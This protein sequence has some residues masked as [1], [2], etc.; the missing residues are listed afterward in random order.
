MNDNLF[1][2]LAA[3]FPADRDLPFLETADGRA[4]SWRELE[5]GT[6]RI[7]NLLRSLDAPAG[8]RVLVQV[9]KSPTAIL[10]YLGALRAGLVFVPINTAYREAETEYFLRDAE[11]AVVVCRPA[12][13]EW[14]SALAAKTG[15]ARVFTLDDSGDGGTLLDAAVAQPDIFET[16]AR[17][18]DDLAVIIYTSGT[19]GRSK[20]AML[21]H[22]NLFSNASTLHAF[23]GWR[24][25][26]VLLHVLPIFHVHGLF[27]A[28]HGALL[29]GARMIWLPKFDPAEVLR[30]LP[31]CTVFMA[32][33]TIYTRLL[34]LP[35][36]N[37]ALCKG[38]RLFVSGSAPLLLETFQ[39]FQTRTGHTILERYG[40]S[41]TVMI[42]S[43][44]YDPAL[45]PRLG[46]TVGLPLP[47]IEVRVVESDGT[48]A[49]PP[50]A[51]GHL[52][53][54][55]PNVCLGYWR[56]PDKTA[57]DFTADRWF[58]TGDM[59]RFGGGVADR[60]VPDTY[61]TIVGRSKELIITGGFNVYPK[62]IEGFLNE[63]PGVAES[64]VFGV[65]H[66]DF[67][68]AVT[69]AV[70]PRAG[71]TLDSE[72]IIRTLKS[73][74]ASFK[75]PKGVHVVAEI[76]RNAMGKVQRNVLRD[77]FG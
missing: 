60:N 58:K 52:E 21:S 55:G 54:R 5:R 35:E 23:W 37:T 72:E 50:G 11:P 69:A 24:A 75:V 45:G 13:A 3:R 47:G 4:Y 36:F 38:M 8:A 30:L 43:N 71:A 77:R 66:P 76:P 39:E 34:A 59:G 42:C 10:L 15:G 68:E 41:E 70:V 40:M 56:A 32:V 65:P 2:L 25:D 6:A 1:A 46:G 61:V 73:Q 44:P 33:P 74:I 51:V 67:G 57:Q 17:A 7:A 14:I 18:A 29:A 26:D 53:V 63:L 20:G 49:C 31:R 62:E 9:E 48:S 28:L 27:V 16:V 12:N 19:T 64:A 22:G